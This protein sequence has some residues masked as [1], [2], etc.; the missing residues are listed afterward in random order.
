MKQKLNIM[1]INKKTKGGVQA[2]CFF[3]LLLFYLITSLPLTAQTGSW[4]AYMSYYEPQQIVK[5]GSNDLFIRASNSLYRYNLNDHSITTYDK[6]R[7]LNDSYISLISWNNATKRLIIVYN[8]SNIDLLDLNDNVINMS[9]LYSKSTTLDKTIN[10]LY[11]HNNYIYIATG[12]GVVKIN[13]ERAEVSESY[14]LNQNITNVAVQDNTIYARNSSGTVYIGAAG[15]NLIDYHN[16][17]TGTAPDGIFNEDNS[18]WNEYIATI[19]TL[20][21]DCPKYNHFYFMRFKNNALYTVGGAYSPYTS[22]I[23]YPGEPQVF[24]AQNNQWQ[25]YD[26]D[27]KSKFTVESDPSK[28]DSWQY[29]SSLS[30]DVDPLDP[31]HVFVGGRPGLFEYYDGV[32]TNYF[33]KD[34]SILL[35]A[36]SSN[37]YVLVESVAFDKEGNLWMLQ[38]QTANSIIEYTK[39]GEWVKHPQSLLM[40]G[41]ISLAALRGMIID[42]RGYLWFVNYH[43]GIPSFYCYDPQR[44]EIVSYITR[45]VNQDGTSAAEQYGPRCIVEDLDGNIWIG[46]SVGLYMIENA[47]IGKPLEYATQVKVPRNDGTNYADYLLANVNITDIVVD[48]GGRKWI[49]TTG[50][51][52]FLISADNMQQL[53]NFTAENSPLLSNNILSLAINNETGELYIGTDIGL[54]SYTTNATTA[55]ETMEKNNVYAYPNPVVSGYDGL[56]TVVGLSLDAD[57]KILSASG[58]LVA[59]GRSNGGTFT[60]DG[61]DRSGKRVAS[62]VYMVAAAT[63]DGKKGTVCKIAVIK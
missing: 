33:N 16:W 21:L 36:T 4:R 60:W 62:G 26:S 25:I 57:V 34:N 55:V 49:A 9:A 43:W 19:N 29:V 39:D 44:D 17:T 53:E 47:A 10:S 37:K 52:L 12:F 6:V 32:L 56:I 27:V 13:V 11:N 18:A 30:I 35:P 48:G 61:R 23:D 58:Q 1:T 28:I 42:S 15:K 63:S 14:I 46:T 31:R 20:Q 54:C 3:G 22:R 2:F 7:Q 38:S 24:D 8:N 59:Q 40:S 5:A 51:G 41:G 45:L 50:N